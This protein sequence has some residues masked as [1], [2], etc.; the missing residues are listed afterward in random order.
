[1]PKDSGSSE[2]HFSI[3]K[4]KKFEQPQTNT[5]WVISKNF[6]IVCFKIKHIYF[7]YTCTMLNID[8]EKRYKQKTKYLF[9]SFRINK[10]ARYL[11]QN[12]VH[13]ICAVHL[14]KSKKLK[15]SRKNGPSPI[16]FW[17]PSIPAK[18]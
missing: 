18:E 2:R 12:T 16:L 5:F 7:F 9:F 8:P 11:L 4:V 3:R 15:D 1:M 14:K 6:K 13:R 10:K 17:T